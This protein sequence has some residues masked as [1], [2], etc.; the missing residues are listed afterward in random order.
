MARETDAALGDPALE[1]AYA[2]ARPCPLP[3]PLDPPMS[4][5]S[6]EMGEIGIGFTPGELGWYGE[7]LWLW[8]WLCPEP[9]ELEFSAAPR[10]RLLYGSKRV[11]SEIAERMQERISTTRLEWTGGEV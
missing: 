10:G 9:E 2:M 5:V 1:R 11:S 3:L 4:M 8:P 7:W 6:V